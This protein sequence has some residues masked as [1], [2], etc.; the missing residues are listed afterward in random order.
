MMRKCPKCGYVRKPRDNKVFSPEECPKCGTIY[1]KYEAHI[2]QELL[3]RET[4]TESPEEGQE[5]EELIYQKRCT[6]CGEGFDPRFFDLLPWKCPACNG[7][8]WDHEARQK[9]R[10]F[11]AYATIAGILLAA[12]VSVGSF[13]AH[14]KRK[15]AEMAN[16]EKVEQ[17]RRTK[18]EREAALLREQQVRAENLRIHKEQE[19]ERLNALQL[20]KSEGKLLA[21]ECLPAY[22]ALKKIDSLMLEGANYHTYCRAM[23]AARQKLDGLPPSLDQAAQLEAIFEFYRKSRDMWHTKKSRNLSKLCEEY[24]HIIDHTK[25]TNEL[26]HKEACIRGCDGLQKDRPLENQEEAYKTLKP[27]VDELQQKLW[28]E[29]AIL[30][31]AYKAQWGLL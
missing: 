22:E 9:E 2:A 15:R 3:R 29:A 21:E 23:D 25:L 7:R 11:W 27:Y 28:M 13:C 20:E 17:L 16:Q 26:T 30:L 10:R 31:K 14:E 6:Q 8:F 4:Q 18:K 1:V 24:R 19:V 12:L 5:S